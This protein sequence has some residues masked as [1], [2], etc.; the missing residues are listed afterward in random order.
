MWWYTTTDIN[1]SVR[2]SKEGEM[3]CFV[4]YSLNKSFHC[5]EPQSRN[6]DFICILQAL[7]FPQQSRRIIQTK[8]SLVKSTYVRLL[9]TKLFQ[10]T[11]C[12]PRW[13]NARPIKVCE[14][15]PYD[16]D[17]QWDTNRP[18]ATF[19]HLFLR[20]WEFCTGTQH[21]Y[22]LLLCVSCLLMFWRCNS[23]FI[24]AVKNLWISPASASA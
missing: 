20:P 1:L 23:L 8:T 2:T 3:N 16:K 14:G 21:L 18:V 22:T 4:S 19:H 6:L 12:Q 7:P 11:N 10:S 9:I 5:S 13:V 24:T 17:I 15:L